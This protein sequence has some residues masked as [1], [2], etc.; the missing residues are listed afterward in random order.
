MKTRSYNSIILRV[1][2]RK[3][4][5]IL[6]LF[7]AVSLLTCPFANFHIRGMNTAISEVT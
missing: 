7:V 3:C 2:N 1:P 6:D 5:P 4:L